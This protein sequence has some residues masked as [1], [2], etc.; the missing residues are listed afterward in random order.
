MRP[1]QIDACVEAIC[2]KGCQAV[3]DDIRRLEHGQELRETAG[4]S[5]PQRQ[6]ILEELRQIMRVY[7]D[8]CRIT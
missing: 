2:N 7:G 3:R 6:R 1:E 5:E 8:S 4:A